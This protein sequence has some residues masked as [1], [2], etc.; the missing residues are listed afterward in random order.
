MCLFTAHGQHIT[1]TSQ[2]LKANLEQI[3]EASDQSLVKNLPFRNIGP[4]IMSGRVVDLA[5]NPNDPK[6]F[7]AGYA[8]GGVW[9]T[10]NNGTSF[11]PVLDQSP[12]QNVGSLAVDWQTHTIWVGTGEINASRSSYAGIGLLKSTDQGKTWQNMGLMDGHHISR[13]LIHPEDSNHI[14]V[15]VLGHLY[16]PNAMRGIYKTT[17]GGKTWAHALFVSEETGVVEMVA[18]P[19]NPNTMYAA[20]WEK[21]RKAWHFKGSGSQSGIYKSV[22]AGSSWELL[23]AEGS[24]FPT[25]A[26]VG[27]IGLAVYDSAVLYAIVDNQDHQNQEADK[28]INKGLEA[29]QFTQ[30]SP[31]AFAQI[32]D[33]MLDEF[34]RNNGFQEEYTAHSVK[35]MVQSGAIQPSDLGR[36]LADANAQLFDTPVI[37]AEVYKST[38]AGRT[39]AKTHEGY[40]DGVYYSYGY[41]FGKIH[42]TPNDPNSIYIYGVPL[43]TSKD[44]GARFKSLDA[45]NMHGDHHVLWINPKNPKHLI[46]GNDGGINISY[47]DG[48]HWVKCNTPSVGQFY[49]INVDNQTPYNVYGGLQDNGVWKGSSRTTESVRWHQ[50]GEYPYKMIMGGDG[51]QVQ[52]DERDVN[53]VYT[54]YQFGNYYRLNLGTDTQTNIQPKHKLGE[55]PNRFNWQ[56]PVLLSAHNQDILYYGSQ[57][58]HRSF[59]QGDHWETLSGDLTQGAK[60]G[61][62][63]YG[64]L[65]TISESPFHFGT[66]YTGSDDG[67]VSVTRNAGADWA[68]ISGNLP[69]DLWVSRVVASEHN[70]ARVYVALNAY[71]GDDFAPY[72][73]LS[74]DYGQTWEAIAHNLPLGAVNVIKEDPKQ[75]S[76]LYVGTDNGVYVRFDIGGKWHAFD[77]DL[78]KVAC[79]DLVVHE[80]AQELILGTHGRS[81][82]IADVSLFQSMDTQAMNQIQ[83]GALEPIKHSKRW[84]QSYS[85]WSDPR[86]PELSMAFM[87]PKTGSAT[88]RLKTEGQKTLMEREITVDEGYNNWTYDL[89]L[90]AAGIK[91]LNKA[92]NGPL[93]AAPNNVTYLPKGKYIIEIRVG[94]QTGETLFKIE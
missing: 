73:Y 85:Q 17:D 92:A 20:T 80:T 71:R 32:D 51:M 1:T 22:D 37:G 82:Y 90:S 49:A 18:D 87:S 61:N 35:K 53:V 10:N 56:T 7:Y 28:A 46:N 72:I 30:M 67:V 33:K 25:G 21:D 47:D 86:T 34:L 9:Y 4:T 55:T 11:T 89:S 65:T 69:Q 44:G 57:R 2:D 66:I 13:I 27:R 63:A 3:E 38:D 93:T 15:G 76:I 8:S 94:D 5:V 43:L 54:G 52:I 36:Y 64:T 24:G 41:Y 75:A 45:A 83:I 42:V 79:H 31:A 70:A 14:V 39:W 26:G 40:L 50:S 78:P 74:E 29:E 60:A 6:E 58:L 68:T 12:T 19:S 77:G 59:D 48:A 23:T 16:S 84:G 88:V 81:I 91:R 62:V